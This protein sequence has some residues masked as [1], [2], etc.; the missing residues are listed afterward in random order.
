MLAL[1]VV[2]LVT[3]TGVASA[4]KP[5]EGT[6]TIRG[7]TTEADFQPLPNGLT[8]YHTL[9]SGGATGYFNGP[10]TYEEWGTVDFDPLTGLGSGKGA[11]LIVLKV[12][13]PGGK[14]TAELIGKT[15]LQGVTG[16]F[17]LQQT[18]GTDAQR[19]L[20]GAGVYSGYTPDQGQTFTVIFSGQFH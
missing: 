13:D 16:G 9:A 18:K 20:T 14:V 6:F 4:A 5:V 19:G 3:L 11:N 17:V 7:H 1:V 2:M 12:N 10:F 15:D 8:W